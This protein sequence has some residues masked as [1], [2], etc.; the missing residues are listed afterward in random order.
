MTELNEVNDFCELLH[1]AIFWINKFSVLSFD[2]QSS[3]RFSTKS[4]QIFS[5]SRSWNFK[6]EFTEESIT[7]GDLNFLLSF[8]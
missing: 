5:K 6:A 4:E 1:E 8:P 3:K 2:S 7:I